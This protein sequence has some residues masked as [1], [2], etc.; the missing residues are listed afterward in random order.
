LAKNTTLYF[1]HYLITVFLRKK[2]E[3]AICAFDKI[4]EGTREIIRPG[5]SNPRN[6]KPKQLYSMN[7]K[8]L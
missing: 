3:K 7:Y 1:N 8:R 2:F 6:K 5:R 4:V